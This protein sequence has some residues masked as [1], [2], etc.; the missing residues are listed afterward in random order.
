LKND[1]L[2]EAKTRQ[3]SLHIIN[4]FKTFSNS[5][6]KLVTDSGKDY[7]VKSKLDLTWIKYAGKAAYDSAQAKLP[8]DRRDGWL[9]RTMNYKLITIRDRMQGDTN[10]FMKDLLNN[11]FHKIPQL[12]FVS[13]PFFAFILLLLYTG[14]KDLYF[15]DHAIFSIHLYISTFIIIFFLLMLNLLEN[16]YHWPWLNYLSVA[17]VLYLVFY[18]YKAMR[19]FYHEG[20]FK[21][22]LKFCMLNIMSTILILLLFITFF[23]LS[24]FEI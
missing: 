13:L 8:P 23:I 7:R 11:L 10:L 15:T 4:L 6:V 21:T 2:K 16:K 14:R 22:F 12:L 1:A 17:L 20:R 5:P 24:F 3:D 19:N 18:T 9:K